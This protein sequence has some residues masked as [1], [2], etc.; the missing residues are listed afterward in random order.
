MWWD[1]RIGG[2]ANWRQEI[3]QHLDA[4]KCV[5]VAW[6]KGSVGPQ[7]HFVRDEA[8]RSLRRGT[9][10]PISLDLVDP[11]LGFGEIQAISLRRWKGDRSDARLAA[12]LNAVKGRISGKDADV[13]AWHVDRPR[14]GRRAV[15]VG[16]IGLGALAATGG[17]LLLR[18]EAAN[19]RRIAVLP[20]VNLS[21]D[22]EQAY[23]SDGIAEELRS[24][25]SRIGMEV[26]GRASSAAVKDLDSK[27]AAAKLNV[28]H[29]LTGSVRRSPSLMR[30]TA[31]LIDGKDGV[32]RW[33]QTYD[34]A[35]GDAIRIQTDIAANVAQALSITLG[36]AGRAAL[37]LGGTADSLA[38]DLVLR[39]RER[40]VTADS[41]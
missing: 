41:S 15:V 29:I 24:A 38:Q 11:P 4:A 23:F 27:A 6:S 21:N 26:I 7:G 28:A 31:Q 16:G 34:R 17:W 32:E 5:I 30:I 39:A 3:E 36:Q 25:L 14:V 40:W 13:G 22:P 10:L 33:A 9:Y 20:F 37:A 35:P 19:A 8:A 18:P 12:L 1:A 2:G